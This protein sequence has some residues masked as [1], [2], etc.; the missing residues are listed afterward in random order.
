MKALVWN[1]IGLAVMAGV[2]LAM[3]GS[4]ALGGAMALL[5]TVI[6]LVSYVIYERV[7]AHVEWG[8]HG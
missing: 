4:A 6:G 2:G 7:W 8:R 3:T 1:A 5:N